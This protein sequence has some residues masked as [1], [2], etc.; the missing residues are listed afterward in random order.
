[1]VQFL[2][3]IKLFILKRL[4]SSKSLKMDLLKHSEKRK[5]AIDNIVQADTL[6]RALYEAAVIRNDGF[7]LTH[8]EVITLLKMTTAAIRKAEDCFY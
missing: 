8:E 1:M 2:Y 4:D 3:Q 5:V 6:V 7:I